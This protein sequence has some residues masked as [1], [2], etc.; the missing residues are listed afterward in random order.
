[1]GGKILMAGAY[2]D[3]AELLRL[4]LGERGYAAVVATGRTDEPADAFDAV[5][6]VGDDPLTMCREISPHARERSMVVV[7][8]APSMPRTVA[9]LRAGAA[10]YLTDPHDIDALDRSLRRVLDRR[11]LE[12]RLRRLD[13]REE[14]LGDSEAILL[15]ESA[16]TRRVRATLERLKSSD[17]TVLLTGESGTGK[18]VVARLLHK[19]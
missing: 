8:P 13:T 14:P 5:L 18:E 17:S 3:E 2:G 19:N 12:E 1:M 15:G 6:V 10:D 7:D 4:K 9:A 16:P 11:A